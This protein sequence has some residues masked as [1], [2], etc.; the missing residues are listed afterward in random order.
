[1]TPTRLENGKDEWTIE[2]SQVCCFCPQCCERPYRASECRYKPRRLPKIHKVV[3]ESDDPDTIRFHF[4]KNHYKWKGYVNKKELCKLLKEENVAFQENDSRA[5]LL[6]KLYSKL[7]GEQATISETIEELLDEEGE[8]GDTVKQDAEDQ[9][10][11]LAARENEDDGEG[12][13]D[14]EIVDDETFARRMKDKDDHSN[15]ELKRLRGIE[16]L[17]KVQRG[18][19]LLTAK[20]L[21]ANLKNRSKSLSGLT[22]KPELVAALQNAIEST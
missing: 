5:V 2:S 8:I 4:L 13:D 6:S 19:A 9:L 18:L 1:M 17:G 15:E 11:Q 3:D 16:L 7:T 12:D 14:D 20:Q 21:K 10:D 22:S